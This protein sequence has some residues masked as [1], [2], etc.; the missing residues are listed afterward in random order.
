M[1]LETYRGADMSCVSYDAQML[2]FFHRFGR[3]T[4]TSTGIVISNVIRLFSLM[5]FAMVDITL[6]VLGDSHK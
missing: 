4:H 2:S 5:D 6:V 1:V 3:L